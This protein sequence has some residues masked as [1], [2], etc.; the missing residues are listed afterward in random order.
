MTSLP[1]VYITDTDLEQLRETVERG[2]FSP[3]AA[4]AELLEQELDRAEVISAPLMPPDVVTMR[5]R[6]RFEDVTTGRT[7]ELSLV[8]P[9]EAD[10][11]AGKLSVLTPVG[12][13]LLGLRVGDTIDWPM[14][15]G[16]TTLLVRAVASPPANAEP[17]S[18]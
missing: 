18:T 2:L 11:E 4:S 14:P 16:K 10:L 8:Y 15:R 6:V 9:P 5:S 12:T 7:R 13:A 17:S 1:R 3:H